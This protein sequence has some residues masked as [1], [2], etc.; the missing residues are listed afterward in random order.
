MSDN[1]VTDSA[2]EQSEEA[3]I[4]SAEVLPTRY[5]PWIPMLAFAQVVSISVIFLFVLT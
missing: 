5:I 2:I 1:I 3:D 4:P